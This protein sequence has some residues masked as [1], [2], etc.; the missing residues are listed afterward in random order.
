MTYES[1][2]RLK[3]SGTVPTHRDKTLRGVRTPTSKAV[4]DPDTSGTLPDFDVTFFE[5]RGDQL[6]H[7]L[8][9]RGFVGTGFCLGLARGAKAAEA[10][11]EAV[12]GL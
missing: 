1:T 10:N 8:R 6:L 5:F 7:F 3:K 4:G 2:E 11:G 12:S 9:G